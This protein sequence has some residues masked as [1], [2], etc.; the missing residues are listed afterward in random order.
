MPMSHLEEL[1]NCDKLKAPFFWLV[2]KREIAE[3]VADTHY[4]VNRV[5]HLI[6]AESYYMVF[7]EGI[8]LQGHSSIGT[9]KHDVP[10]RCWYI[11]GKF[12]IR[13]R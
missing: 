8:L 6:V 10:R 5:A 11:M 4:V 7:I 12:Y 1:Y 9:K 13:S 3:S 2:Y